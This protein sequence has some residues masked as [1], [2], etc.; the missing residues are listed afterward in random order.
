LSELLSDALRTKAVILA[1]EERYKNIGRQ[2]CKMLT[3]NY[4]LK[5]TVK[6]IHWKIKFVLVSGTQSNP[7]AQDHSFNK[8]ATHQMTVHVQ[9]LS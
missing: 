7:A 9:R 2:M 1:F 3:T 6:K 5:R 8:F 4:L